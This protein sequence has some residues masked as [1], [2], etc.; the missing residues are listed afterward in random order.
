[1]V[2]VVVVQTHSAV[3]IRMWLRGISEFRK[4]GSSSLLLQL[5]VVWGSPC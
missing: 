3:N 2:L 4:R 5:I 1:M